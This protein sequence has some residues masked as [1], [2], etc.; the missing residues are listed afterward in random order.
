MNLQPGTVYKIEDKYYLGKF[1]TVTEKDGNLH[2][3]KD[4]KGVTRLVSQATLN[5]Y[6]QRVSVISRPRTTKTEKEIADYCAEAASEI[7]AEKEL[8]KPKV[9]RMFRYALSG[10]CVYIVDDQTVRVAPTGES[11][12]ATCYCV[13]FTRNGECAHTESALEFYDEQEERRAA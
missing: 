10:I 9:K 7:A 2:L 5:R 6:G 13:D 11:R 8:N 12:I 1:F 4:E 3:V